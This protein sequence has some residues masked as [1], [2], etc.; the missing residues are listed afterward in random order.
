MKLGRIG[1]R[2]RR[3]IFFVPDIHSVSA[4]KSCLSA[5][6]VH[7]ALYYVRNRCFTVCARNAYGY[8]L[9]RGIAVK[10]RRSKRKIAPDVGRRKMF[11]R[12]LRRACGKHDSRRA[13]AFG[14]NHIGD[15][16]FSV[17]QAKIQIAFAAGIA[18]T[19]TFDVDVR[20]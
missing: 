14:E 8:Q 17:V 12:S 16:P 7:N 3:G 18:V 13:S 4:Y 5:G 6:F 20:V 10:S 1:S 9:V 19:D 15:E 2:Q 11:C